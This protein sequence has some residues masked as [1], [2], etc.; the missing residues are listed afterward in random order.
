MSGV[1][2]YKD[3]RW[4]AS[5]SFCLVEESF[6]RWYI[7]YTHLFLFNCH[8]QV[9]SRQGE[10]LNVAH[11]SAICLYELSRDMDEP[12]KDWLPSGKSEKHEL[13]HECN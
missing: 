1:I 2:S 9:P 4:L 5:F 13:V 3:Q 8:F 10:S 6:G 12:I 11:A 7:V